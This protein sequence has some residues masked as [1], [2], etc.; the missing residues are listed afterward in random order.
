MRH[1]SL[2]RCVE[3]IRYYYPRDRIIVADCT[4]GQRPDPVPPELRAVER[5]SRI[6][7]LPYDAGIAAMRN[8]L[9]DTA[10]TEHVVIIEEDMVVTRETDIDA[11]WDV[12][13]ETGARIVYGATRRFPVVTC[14]VGLIR[15]AE[16][17]I[18]VAMPEQY[19]R[20][21]TG[22]E[23]CETHCGLNFFLARRDVLAG[24]GRWD[25]RYRIVG[26]HIDWT[27]RLWAA[28]VPQAYTPA[29]VVAHIRDESP[30]AYGRMRGR[31][32]TQDIIRTEHG[33][34]PVLM[35]ECVE[36]GKQV[37]PPERLIDLGRNI[38]VLT[39]G[40]TGSSVVTA[41]LSRLGWYVPG[42]DSFAED[43]ELRAIND[44]VRGGKADRSKAEAYLQSLPRPWAVKDPRFCETLSWWL[45]VMREYAPLLLVLDRSP[46]DVLRSYVRRGERTELAAARMRAVKRLSRQWPWEVIRLRYEQIREAMEL[47]DPYPEPGTDPRRGPL[48]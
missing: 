46:E 40:H 21:S 32:D 19:A 34:V 45:P 28:R 22:V 26:E 30:P 16:G 29:S 14:W 47:W 44:T 17:R 3:S 7:W 36:W 37:V 38:V 4:F 8:A 10:E 13:Q 23:Y 5:V 15:V 48:T 25:D 41:M 20:T 18:W 1:R 27:L 43:P 6:L 31:K 35:R 33:V 2:K 39:P 24:V 42:M 12:M 9:V 11:M